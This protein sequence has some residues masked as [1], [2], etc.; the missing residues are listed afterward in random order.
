MQ[1]SM[2][3]ILLLIIAICSML[4]IQLEYKPLTDNKCVGGFFTEKGKAVFC[5]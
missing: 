1:H 5:N 2:T 3:N 4:F